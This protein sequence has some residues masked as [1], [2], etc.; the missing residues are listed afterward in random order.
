[1]SATFNISNLPPFDVGDEDWRTNPFEERGNDGN[2]VTTKEVKDENQVKVM[3][4]KEHLILKLV[5]GPLCTDGGI[6]VIDLKR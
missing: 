5:D 4:R 1:M 3:E 2:Q 6:I